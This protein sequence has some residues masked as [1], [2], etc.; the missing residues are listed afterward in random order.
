MDKLTW[1]IGEMILEMTVLM[2]FNSAGITAHTK[3]SNI[4]DDFGVEN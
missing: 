3:L 2:A 1:A 4:P